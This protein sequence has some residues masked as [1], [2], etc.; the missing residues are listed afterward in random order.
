MRQLRDG[1][2]EIEGYGS[3][4]SM[5]VTS[6]SIAAMKTGRLEIRYASLVLESATETELRYLRFTP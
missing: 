2:V 3:S 5:R 4:T 1:D 6:Y